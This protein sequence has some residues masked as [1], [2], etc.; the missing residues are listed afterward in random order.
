[1]FSLRGVFCPKFLSA[2]TE[3]IHA[4]KCIPRCRMRPHSR[5]GFHTLAGQAE[6]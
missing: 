3:H 4:T 2:P 1:M 6:Q 5:E